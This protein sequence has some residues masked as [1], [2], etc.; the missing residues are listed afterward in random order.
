MSDMWEGIEK[1]TQA[2]ID[3]SVSEDLTHVSEVYFCRSE[4]P[5]GNFW[6]AH[7]EGE[8]TLLGMV[9]LEYLSGEECELRRMSVSKEARRLGIGSLLL[10][11]LLSFASSQGFQRC[12][13]STLER[14]LPG[15][16]LYEKLGFQEYKRRTIVPGIDE[17]SYQYSLSSFKSP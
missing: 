3:K 6:V 7:R 10:S 15:R 13:L 14:M 8:S 16:R 5:R 12:I 17:V 9:G 1:E 11:H 2:Y 4:S